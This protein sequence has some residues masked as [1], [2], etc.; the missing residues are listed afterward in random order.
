MKTKYFEVS[1][2]KFQ[3]TNREET[4]LHAQ[5]LFEGTLEGLPEIAVAV[6]QPKAFP[7]PFCTRARKAS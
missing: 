3:Q 4:L 5:P 2:E 6:S 1:C 7:V